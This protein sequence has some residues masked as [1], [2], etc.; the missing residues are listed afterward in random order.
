MPPQCRQQAR[1]GT[2]RA[3]L[4]WEITHASLPPLDQPCLEES[5]RAPR[6]AAPVPLSTMPSVRQSA[7]LDT[8]PQ[9]ARRP[10]RMHTQSPPSQETARHPRSPPHASQPPLAVE[11]AASAVQ[12]IT[13][14]R[15]F[16]T[17]PTRALKPLS[18]A[19]RPLIDRHHR[20]CL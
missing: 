11:D 18:I 1:R 8:C 4:V 7:T 2:S 12:S 3:N 9:T 13:Y 5:T 14:S 16:A 17:A 6:N 19:R 20:P 15:P 10:C